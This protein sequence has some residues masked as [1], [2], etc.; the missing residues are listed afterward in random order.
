[1]K[2]VIVKVKSS[3]DERMEELSLHVEQKVKGVDNMGEKM[4][5]LENCLK[6]LISK[7]MFGMR[8]LTEQRS[9]V[10]NF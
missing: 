8:K 4:K 10:K 5:R 9:M 6:L 2:K 3:A 1:M 7:R